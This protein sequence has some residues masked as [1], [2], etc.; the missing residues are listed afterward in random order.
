M[1]IKKI[2]IGSLARKRLQVYFYVKSQA[3]KSKLLILKSD[4]HLGE[5]PHAR[6]GSTHV[7][8]TAR[9]FAAKTAR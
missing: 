9:P 6:S 2:G 8:Y 1:T 3:T 5:E 4:M 7:V